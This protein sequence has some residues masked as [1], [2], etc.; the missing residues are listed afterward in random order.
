MTHP[1]HSTPPVAPPRTTVPAI[2][3]AIAVLLGAWAILVLP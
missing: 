2:L 3:A 1:E